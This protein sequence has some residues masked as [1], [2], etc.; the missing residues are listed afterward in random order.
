MGLKVFFLIKILLKIFW[1]R[2]C[3][4][5]LQKILWNWESSKYFAPLVL[6]KSD[7]EV[8]SWAENSFHLTPVFLRIRL[9]IYDYDP[10]LGDCFE[11]K[12]MEELNYILKTLDNEE[13][14]A[15]A[16]IKEKYVKLKEIYSQYCELSRPPE[17]EP[18]NPNV[19]A[20]R[21]ASQKKKKKK[22]KKF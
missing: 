5:V 1:L 15:T 3:K 11:N 14:V 7:E 18:R 2:Q 20:N 19:P 12:T 13:K 22:K 9:E 8:N 10:N 17:Q 21:S 16:A 6:Q 4:R